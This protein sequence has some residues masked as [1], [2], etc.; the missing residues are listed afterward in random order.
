MKLLLIQ[1]QPIYRTHNNIKSFQMY[2]F[3]INVQSICESLSLKYRF[4]HSFLKSSI[5]YFIL[6]FF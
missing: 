5:Y 1:Q 4:L 3:I 2:L 6:K